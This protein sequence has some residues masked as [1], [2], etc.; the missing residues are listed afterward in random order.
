M[1]NIY[2]DTEFEGL[3]PGAALIS[4]GLTDKTGKHIFYRE[5]TDTYK[6]ENCSKYCQE[7]VLPL[8][9]GGSV[10]KTFLEVKLDL[11]GWL[12]QRGPDTVLIC[13]N[14]KDVE[15]INFIYPKGLPFNCKIKVIGA[16][17]KW[18]RRIMSI[19]DRVHKMHGL[20]P[21]HA[22]DDAIANRI[23]FEGK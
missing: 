15:Q 19:N 7:I 5:L 6:K 17:D 13:D 9:E 1:N 10:Q 14:Q 16:V 18:K 3:F 23:I 4:I 8:L 21:H 22:L 12:A 2:F 11:W 20:R